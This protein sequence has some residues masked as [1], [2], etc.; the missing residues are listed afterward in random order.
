MQQ[1]NINQVNHVNH[2]L[3][4]PDFGRHANDQTDIR[5]EGHGVSI[6]LPFL[7]TLQR[8]LFQCKENTSFF[9]ERIK[10]SKQLGLEVNDFESPVAIFNFLLPSYLLTLHSASIVESDVTLTD[11][12]T[13]L[14]ATPDAPAFSLTYWTS[15]YQ[16]NF[17]RLMVRIH[18]NGDQCHLQ[19]VSAVDGKILASS[20]IQ[21]ELTEQTTDSLPV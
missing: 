4:L 19:L 17:S 3:N 2:A 14:R 7:P 21:S 10:T 15:K 5:I 16:L 8:L 13:V 18:M 1:L 9:R 12:D 11:F 20:L 6:R